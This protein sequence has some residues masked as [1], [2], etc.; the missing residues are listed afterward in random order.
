MRLAGLQSADAHALEVAFTFSARAIDQRGDREMF[1]EAF[2]SDR[3]AAT[4][5]DVSAHFSPKL[6]DG[7]EPLLA[8]R[9]AEEWTGGAHREAV[10]EALR[11][12]AKPVAFAC[13]VEVLPPFDL[14]IESPTLEREKLEAMQRKL[15]E[16]RAAGQAEHVQRAAELLRQFE[17]LRQTMP[18]LSPGQLLDRVSPADRGS[19]LQTLLLASG[20]GGAAAQLR[21][22]AGTSVIS[23]DT[24]ADSPRPAVSE[25]PSDL[26]P[27]RSV[28]PATLAGRRGLLVG[29]Q[30]GVLFADAAAA[31]DAVRFRDAGVTSPLGFNA[32]VVAG[33]LIWASHGDAGVVAWRADAP[34]EPPVRTIRQ[35]G[36]RNV[37]A[38]DDQ[39][40]IYSAGGDVFV[41]S[42]DDGEQPRRVG[43]S[44]STAPVIFLAADAGA[45]MVVRSDG[46]VESLNAATL[47]PHCAGARRC[48]D[49]TAA[50]LLPW[51]GSH[52]LLL[53]T[54]DGPVQCVGQD[55]PLVT[56]Y[57]SAHRGLRA[58][59]ASTDTI[60]ALSSDRQ[61]LILWRT[62]DASKPAAEIHVAGLT[63]HR[64]ADVCF[65]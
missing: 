59:A 31:S 18:G 38:V 17:A 36:S 44:G 7:A 50:C 48:G 12:A 26:G 39:R 41:A 20:G 8:Q 14:S 28:Q 37:V 51:L 33:D 40:V 64:A 34:G 21:A 47:E 43:T 10:V 6:H 2:L 62:W 22:V 63:R 9:S 25:L 65:A 54:E 60:A 23:V 42:A 52:R 55:D 32:A 53:A 35:Q 4:S 27:L 19:M 5:D 57:A 16:R 45:V 29:A 61:R 56:Q 30:V 46:F 13:G 24:R 3:D 49:V 1:A 11:A 15:A 58:I